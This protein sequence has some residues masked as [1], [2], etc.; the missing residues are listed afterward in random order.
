MPALQPCPTGIVGEVYISGAGL[1]RGYWNRPALTAER[2][3][4]NPFAAEPGERMYRTGDLGFWREDGNL[5]FQGRA[6]HQIKL[7]GFRI[8]PAEIEAALLRDG[9]IRQAA[10]IDGQDPAGGNRLI[11]YLVPRNQVDLLELRRR[12]T[13]RL[14]DYMVPGAFVILENLPLT[15]NR[16]LDRR[17]LPPPDNWGVATGYTAPATPE[18]TLLCELVAELL[19]IERAGVTDN[20]FHLGGTFVDGS[21][22]RC[23]HPRPIGTRIAGAEGVRVSGPGSI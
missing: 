5:V 12:L 15:A 18:E 11:A 4:A 20:F 2:F 21:P 14:P 8:E 1:A 23:P 10:V 6:D 9:D 3:V 13:A 19:G 7:R 16:K 22:A 17:A